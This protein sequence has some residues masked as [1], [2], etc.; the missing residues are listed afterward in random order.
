MGKGT[1]LANWEALPEAD[2]GWIRGLLDGGSECM[3]S[4]LPCMQD[5]RLL[6]LEV[7]NLLNAGKATVTF[8]ACL[9]N[10]L[11]CPRHLIYGKKLHQH[12][13]NNLA[14][15]CILH[16][17]PVGNGQ[18]H[19][20]VRLFVRCFSAKCEALYQPLAERSIRWMELTAAHHMRYR[21]L[22]VE[23][24]SACGSP[25][26]PAIYDSPTLPEAGCPP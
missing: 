10:P 3:L 1:D 11:L 19:K 16:D 6:P 15:V 9:I 13:G 7:F 17:M 8:Y 5:E 2:A 20:V 14:A 24:R 18:T 23:A 22:K 4:V 21:K 26:T 25:A 12:R